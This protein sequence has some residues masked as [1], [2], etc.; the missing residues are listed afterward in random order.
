MCVGGCTDD[1][2][3]LHHL[4]LHHLLGI[5]HI[6]RSLHTCHHIRLCCRMRSTASL[7][8]CL[9]R[10]LKLQGSSPL[11]SSKGSD[12]QNRMM[13]S[14]LMRYV[15]VCTTHVHIQSLSW[16][17]CTAT[18][19]IS[20]I[21][22]AMLKH[23]LVGLCCLL[24]SSRVCHSAHRVTLVSVSMQHPV[25]PWTLMFMAILT[26]CSISSTLDLQIDTP[27]DTPARD[28]FAR[29]R[30]LKSWRSSPWDPRE[31]LPQEY[32]NTFAFENFKRAHKRSVNYRHFECVQHQEY[33]GLLKGAGSLHPISTLR[34]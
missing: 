8:V 15:Y 2:S 34:M 18:L 9:C 23:L 16:C 13:L 19:L 28:R 6:S 20:I 22:S 21:C 11:L 31:G 29:Y 24:N 3:S 12:G 25:S 30:G 32:A 7:T 5:S 4:G 26:T 14:F 17:V 33:A 1:K 27:T 10:T